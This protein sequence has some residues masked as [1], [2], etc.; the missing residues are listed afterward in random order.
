MEMSKLVP[1][2]VRRFDFQ[3]EGD[4][5]IHNAWFVKQTDFKC[6]ITKRKAEQE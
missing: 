3:I 5:K 1:Q 6:F 2:L 4:W